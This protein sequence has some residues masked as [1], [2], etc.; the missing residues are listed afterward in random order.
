MARHWQ[1]LAGLPHRRIPAVALERAELAALLD[2][3]RVEMD[4]PGLRAAVRF[5]DGSVVRASVG[6]ADVENAV[7]LDDSVGMPGGSTGRTFVAALTMLFVEEGLLALDDPAAKWLGGAAWFDELPNAESMQVRHLLSHSSGMGDYPATMGYNMRSVWRAIRHGTIRFETGEL[8]GF[9]PREPLFAPGEGY[10]YTDA[11]YLV[12]GRVI[13]AASG[14][15]Y[16]DLLEERIL[17]P[18]GLDQVRPQDR[19][20]LP[21]ITPG[22]MAG[23]RNLRDDSSM[24]IDPESEWTGGGLV[25]NPTMLARFFGALAEGIVVSDQSLELMLESG[26]T[27]AVQTNRDGGIDLESLV[28]RIRELATP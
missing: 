8:I 3:A 14:R 4:L 24:K 15:E 7:A 22:Y 23:A 9:A 28:T 17:A 2:A 26:I 25:T 13:E 19:P 5:S 6:L 10:A 27:I 21:D 1:S 16:F 12:L 20:I 18:L 11:G